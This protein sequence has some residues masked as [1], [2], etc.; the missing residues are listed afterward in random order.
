MSRF[1]IDSAFAAIAITLSFVVGCGSGAGG[2]QITGEVSYN[3][4]PLEAG[5]VSFASVGGGAAPF[6]AKVIDG[7]YSADKAKPGQYIAT[8]SATRSASAGPLTR[9]ELAKNPNY[10]PNYIPEDAA[11]NKQTVDVVVGAQLDFALTG[12]PRP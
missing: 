4:A 5:F 10:S 3:G 9:E 2:S 12:P 11:G 1:Q 8:V 6:G 7:K